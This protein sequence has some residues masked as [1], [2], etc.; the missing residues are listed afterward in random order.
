MSIMQAELYEAL[1]AAKVPE[2]KARA[3]ATTLT[4]TTN[5][6]KPEKLG[7]YIQ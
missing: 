3:A 2:D 7:N 1:I 4:I 6:L 5:Y